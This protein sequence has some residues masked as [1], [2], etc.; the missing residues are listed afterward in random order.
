MNRTYEMPKPT[1]AKLRSREWRDCAGVQRKP[2]QHD[3]TCSII[4]MKVIGTMIHTYVDVV[5]DR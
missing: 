5:V 2:N 1:D 4:E 3:V